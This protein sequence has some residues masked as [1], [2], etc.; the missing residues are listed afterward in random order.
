M[1]IHLTFLVFIFAGYS[2]FAQVNLSQS[3][4]A[5][6]ALDANATEPI[7]N[8]TGT[9][10]AVSP[11][12]S[13]LNA[14][15]Q[16]MHFT[17]VGTSYI[18]LPET[19]L[20]KPTQAI[21]FSTWVNS[22]VLPGGTAYILFNKNSVS[23]NFEAYALI[24][25]LSGSGH[26]FRVVKGNAGSVTNVD[27]S[28]PVSTGTWYHVAFTMD[29]TE[30]KIY[31]NGA[32]ENT[33]LTNLTFDY[34]TGKKVYLGSSNESS[35]Y[36]PFTGTLDNARFYNRILSASEVSQL[37]ATDP[38]CVPSGVPPV[39]SYS[40]SSSTI[41]AG[42]SVQFTDLSTN[43]PTSW[44]WQVT[45]PNFTNSSQQNPTIVFSSSGNYTVALSSSNNFGTS[46]TFTQV[47]TVKPLPAVSIVASRS[48]VC[49]GETIILSGSGASS[50][51]WNTNPVQ[52]SSA[53]AIS[54]T[55]NTSYTVTG[56]GLNGC[57]NTATTIVKI[58]F[59]TQ[60]TEQKSQNISVS[61][62]PNPTS[63]KFFIEVSTGNVTNI[64]IV[65][66][67][68][69]TIL[70][71]KWNGRDKNEIDLSRYASGIYFLNVE[72]EESSKTFKIIK[73]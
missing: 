72:N 39:A 67:I 65:N 69:E 19:P 24:T 47:V 61:V 50:Y 3:L 12:T 55:A 41:C 4:T 63:G 73:E 68:G 28:T 23:S 62:F 34:V 7:N 21:S 70:N 64:L 15:N 57:I 14:S 27:S 31:V 52:T 53:I 48:I 33:S 38:A 45:G 6:Y 25:F 40:M 11:T 18:E 56:L 66:L 43:V 59:C 22:D 20:L 42:A 30:L 16:A 9:L 37:Y 35:F 54:P 17:G 26:K 49:L 58:S 13:H 5:C 60:I 44:N 10:S 8:L 36:S 29:N 51:T 32:L 1:K 2:V 71:E 46:N